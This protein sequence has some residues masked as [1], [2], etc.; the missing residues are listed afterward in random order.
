VAIYAEMGTCASMAGALRFET[1]VSLPRWTS[2]M[3]FAAAD[4]GIE[5]APDDGFTDEPTTVAMVLEADSSDG[6]RRQVRD[7]LDACG[8]SVD[9]ADFRG[10]TRRP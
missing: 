5:V 8:V 10:P 1:L 7:M 4:A 2:E 6:A 3:A 9:D